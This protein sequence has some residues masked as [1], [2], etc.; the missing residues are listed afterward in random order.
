MPFLRDFSLRGLILPSRSMSY[1][2]YLPSYP[3]TISRIFLK[4]FKKKI[5]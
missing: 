2:L 1:I 3:D 5:K 4:A